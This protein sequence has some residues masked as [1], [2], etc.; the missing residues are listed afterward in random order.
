MAR[1]Q[2][3]DI[4]REIHGSAREIPVRSGKQVAELSKLADGSMEFVQR[5]GSKFVVPA[6]EKEMTAFVVWTM[7]H[8]GAQ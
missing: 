3:V 1:K 6:D 2:S 7:I 5:D 8:H 4:L